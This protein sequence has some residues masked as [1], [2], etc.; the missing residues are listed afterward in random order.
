V[1]MG[2]RVLT[3]RRGVHSTPTLASIATENGYR[4][5]GWKDGGLIGPGR[6]ADFA[7][8]RLDSVR[9]AGTDTGNALDAVMFAASSGDVHNLVVA[10]RPVVVGGAHVSID[11]PAELDSSIAKVVAA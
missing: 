2:Q 10:G 9:L 7:T 6:L 4:A 3:N 8:V 5:L 11:V 1:E